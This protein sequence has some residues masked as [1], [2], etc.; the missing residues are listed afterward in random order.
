MV[1]IKLKSISFRSNWK[2]WCKIR[3]IGINYI[4]RT[5]LSLENHH[6]MQDH[7]KNLLK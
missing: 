5:I 7:S 2:A 3:Q 6:H 4:S 1:E